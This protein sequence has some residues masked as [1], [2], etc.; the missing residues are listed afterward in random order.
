MGT[1]IRNCQL[2]CCQDWGIVWTRTLSVNLLKLK[3]ATKDSI[4]F[5]VFW[6]DNF[7]AKIDSDKKMINSTHI[8]AF[9]E[10]NSG[11]IEPQNLIV[12]LKINKE[13]RSRYFKKSKTQLQIRLML[14]LLQKKKKYV[15]F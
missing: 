6:A 13:F 15:N 5:T 1:H 7:N 2:R 9:Q 12:L 14:L 8:I 3:P 10:L 11:A 4:V